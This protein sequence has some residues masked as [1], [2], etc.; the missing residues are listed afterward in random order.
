MN[1][2]VSYVIQ[3]NKSHKH[4]SE[5]VT[6]QNPSYSYSANPEVQDILQWAEKKKKTLKHEE[7]LII[8]SMYKL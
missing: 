2:Y 6:T 5:V 8:V 4:L 7:E 3:D 1:T